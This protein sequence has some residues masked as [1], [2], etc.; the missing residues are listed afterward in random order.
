[1]DSRDVVGKFGFDLGAKLLPICRLLAC[2]LF[3]YSESKGHVAPDRVEVTVNR[4]KS[5]AGVAG[6]QG[7]ETIILQLGEPYFFMIRKNLRQ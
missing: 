1:M 5:G 4:E 3:E 2:S 7:Q 6:G